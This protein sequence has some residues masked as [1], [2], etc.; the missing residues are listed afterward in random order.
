MLAQAFGAQLLHEA[1]EEF[2]QIVGVH[3]SNR[4]EAAA[5][6]LAFKQVHAADY[7]GY[8]FDYRDVHQAESHESGAA[9][10]V[11]E[12]L[13]RIGPQMRCGEHPYCQE[14]HDYPKQ[15]RPAHGCKR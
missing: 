4:C 14:C 13:G 15:K 3:L 7:G 5:E 8:R 2:H 1:V 6:I 9:H 11:A 10:G 12:P